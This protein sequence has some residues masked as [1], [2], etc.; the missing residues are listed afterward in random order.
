MRKSIGKQ[1]SSHIGCDACLMVLHWFC[2]AHS[3]QRIMRS[4][5]NEITQFESRRM[6]WREREKSQKNATTA[7][8]L[9]TYVY[10][11]FFSPIFWRYSWV[12]L[13][14]RLF[15]YFSIFVKT[16]FLCPMPSCRVKKTIEWFWARS[17]WQTE[18]KH[19]EIVWQN[20]MSS[21]GTVVTQF[22]FHFVRK[23]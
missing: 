14:K 10:S 6:R 2:R 20:K 11:L 16:V 21:V 19:K 3:A 23:I 12:N 5:I 1:H 13:N 7:G 9:F 17:E 8:K 15:L 18:R 4:H 22:S